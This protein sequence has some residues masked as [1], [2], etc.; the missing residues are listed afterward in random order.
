MNIFS[1]QNMCIHNSDYRR[2]YEL[3]SLIVT[4]ITEITLSLDTVFDTR[5]FLE[6]CMRVALVQLINDSAAKTIEYVVHVPAVL[7]DRIMNLLR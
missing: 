4:V 2:G 1:L 5:A 6:F 3:H 7:F